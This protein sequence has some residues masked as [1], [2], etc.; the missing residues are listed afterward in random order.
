MLE[1]EI[2]C[3]PQLQLNAKPQKKAHA[4]Q[5][6]IVIILYYDIGIILCPLVMW[7]INVSVCM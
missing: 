4:I 2:D 5:I 6:P 1:Q 3:W 7:L